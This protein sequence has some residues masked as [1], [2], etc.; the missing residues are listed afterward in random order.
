MQDEK[1]LITIGIK[2]LSDN[3]RFRGD[4]KNSKYG[5]QDPTVEYSRAQSRVIRRVLDFITTS[6]DNNWEF[7]SLLMEMKGLED[8]VFKL[9][10]NIW[11]KQARIYKPIEIEGE[12]SK[13][14]G[15]WIKTN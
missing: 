10:F 1:E 9:F 14:R 12:Y 4:D 3:I 15:R 2:Y 11:S 13:V 6:E 7:R 5:S 8:G